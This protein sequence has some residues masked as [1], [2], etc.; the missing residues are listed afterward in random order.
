M[1]RILSIIT[2]AM[3]FTCAFAEQI[4]VRI[5][6][7][8]VWNKRAPQCAVWLEDQNHNY[9]ETI[10]VTKSASKKTWKFAPKEG[11][12]ESLPAWYKC[13]KVNS[14]KLVNSEQKEL[15]AVT[16]ATP[17]KNVLA[18]KQVKLQKGNIY[19]IRTEINQSFDYNDYWTKKNSGVDGQPSVIYEGVLTADNGKQE[20]P[21]TFAGISTTDINA[22][23]NLTTAR[24]IIA[25]I[26]AYIE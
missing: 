19:Y 5:E 7:G 11:R 13:S 3:F 4:T 10:F 15:D 20:I 14:E 2:V 17:K 18:E 22:V 1:K 16:C 6:P 25:G 12:P 8:E 21:L 24:E 26:T 9:V 23:K